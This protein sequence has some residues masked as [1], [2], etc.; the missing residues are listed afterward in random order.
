MGRFKLLVLV[1]VVF[2]TTF[3]FLI[4]FRISC[5][6]NTVIQICALTSAAVSLFTITHLRR[7]SRLT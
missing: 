5:L 1:S 2:P 3:F 6:P 4:Y 7:M